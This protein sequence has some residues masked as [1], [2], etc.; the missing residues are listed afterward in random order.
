MHGDEVVLGPEPDAVPRARRFVAAALARLGRARLI[1]DTE[2]A[3]S[4]LVTNGLLYAGPPV[5]LIVAAIGDN[6]VRLEVHDRSRTT[7]VRPRPETHT[8][9]GRGLALVD[10]VASRWGVEATPEGKVVWVELTPDSVEAVAPAVGDVDA[11]LAMFADDL[12]PDRRRYT[13]TLG[14]VSTGL[15]LEAKTHMDSLVR[16]FTLASRGA[17]AGMTAKMPSNLANLVEAVV[18]EFAEARM[19]IKRQ[20]MESAG[21]GRE[22]T[23]LTVSLPA[24]A[25]DAGERYLAA[26]A[27]ADAYARAARLLTLEAPPQHRMFRRWYVTSLVTAL[28]QAAAGQ[29]MTPGPTFEEF[30]LGEVDHLD[31][32]QR[33]SDRSARLQRV[34]AALGGALTAAEVGR[35]VL[36]EAIN[37]LGARRGALLTWDRGRVRVVVDAGYPPGLAERLRVASDS[38][39]LPG[40]EALRSGQP[41]WVE[42]TEQRDARYPQLSRLEP[43]SIANAAVPLYVGSRMVGALRFSFGEP[44]LFDH[45]EQDFLVAL[46]AI[47]GQALERAELYQARARTAERLG[48]LQ[49]ATAA[50]ASTRDVDAV[51][52]VLIEHATGLLGAEVGALCLLDEDRHTMRITRIR[53]ESPGTADTW[54]RFDV[55]DNVPASEAVRTRQIVVADSVAERDARWPSL[56]GLPPAYEHALIALPLIVGHAVLGSITLS[57]S[58]AQNVSGADRAALSALADA[59][60]QA[61][62]HA[63]NAVR[64]EVTT[65]RLTFLGRACAELA[66]TS[67]VLKTLT[68]IANKAVPALADWCAV[69]LVEND[70]LAPL[71]VIHPDPDKLGTVEELQSRWPGRLTA[72]V[73]SVV[74]T[75]EAMFVPVVPA[76]VRV[77][78]IALLP[79]P[80]RRDE[81]RLL[82]AL[83]FSS[84]IIV[85]MTAHGRTTGAITFIHAQSGQRYEPGD[86]TAAQCLAS[87]AALAL[88][89]ERRLRDMAAGIRPA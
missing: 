40:M 62:D 37:E 71:V 49:R 23:T 34:T 51:A 86:L 43:D 10:A 80:D 42:T 70:Q 72:P 65:A 7:P 82:R 20:A 6:A 74:R 30:L 5:R 89:T 85:P 78:P 1:D 33:A 47:V 53:T 55:N 66:D 57:F 3:T 61:L 83:G 26:L 15:L 39:P 29:P 58:A 48:R 14:D 9:T 60:A 27:E 31:S 2:L 19:A 12:E 84:A 16:E 25:A 87:S 76:E 69:H 52:D 73:A 11:W 21:C 8:M 17:A 13:V 36:T 38:T 79:E 28:R 54:A 4:E 88:D 18:N 77:P 81:Q 22:R 32:L 46:A 50:L 24:D 75:G 44:R 45:D 67:D 63:R 68:D 35:I 64:A 41:V 59:C 56:A